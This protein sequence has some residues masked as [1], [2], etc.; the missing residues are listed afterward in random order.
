MAAIIG[1]FL[2][3][4]RARMARVDLN[5][6]R[7]LF[8]L[9]KNS[10]GGQAKYLRCFL[11]RF[12]TAKLAVLVFFLTE[13]RHKGDP[14]QAQKKS[15]LQCRCKGLGSLYVLSINLGEGFLDAYLLLAN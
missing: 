3:S 14:L 12:K 1:V 10:D 9:Y 13:F 15:P 4:A 7:R 5:F 11:E 2:K 8:R 6:E